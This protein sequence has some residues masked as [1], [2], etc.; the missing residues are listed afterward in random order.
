LPPDR[1]TGLVF[2]AVALIAAYLWRSNPTTLMIALGVAAVLAAVSLLAPRTLRPLNIAWMRLAALLSRIMNPIVMLIL[3]AI[4]IIP[5]GLI[6][7]LVR[8]PLRLR[9]G[10]ADSYWIP[11]D[12]AENTHPSNMKNQF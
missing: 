11:M 5:S 10:S 12:R 4:A 7:Q 9:K 8:D 2:A 3:F 6:M 1:S